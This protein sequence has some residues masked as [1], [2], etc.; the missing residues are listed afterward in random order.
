[1][2]TICS[3]RS[4][5]AFNFMNVASSMMSSVREDVD[6]IVTTFRT[7]NWTQEI[8]SFGKAVQ[9]EANEAMKSIE[10]LPEKANP[11]QLSKNRTEI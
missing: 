11:P 5:K 9:E 10:T 4:P 8:F 3:Q 2:Q 1:M 7:T 6:D